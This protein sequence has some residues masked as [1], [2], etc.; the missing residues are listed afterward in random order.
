[1]TVYRA[2]T[3]CILQGQ[4]CEARDAMRTAL[5]GLNVTSVKWRCAARRT[6][7]NRGDP[8]WVETVGDQSDADLRGEFPAVAIKDVGPKVLVFI[9]AG[10]RDR[11][12]DVEFIPG[13]GARGFCKIPLS[14][15]TAREGGKYEL[16]PHCDWPAYKGHQSGYSCNP[17]TKGE[18]W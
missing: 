16:C 1:M 3:G 17:E 15:I 2:C 11:G 14:R 18:G 10:V 6:R 8:V 13:A 5:K 9:E 7:V 12:G 4:P